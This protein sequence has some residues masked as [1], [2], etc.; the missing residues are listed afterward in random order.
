MNDELEE[1]GSE[2]KEAW[3]CIARRMDEH[4]AASAERRASR[5]T[6][7]S[8]SSSS[9]IAEEGDDER[10]ATFAP[11]VSLSRAPTQTEADKCE[12]SDALGVEP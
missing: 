5:S 3:A 2:I 11:D 10:V 9:R 1:A 12:R 8:S 7:S 4:A 6:S